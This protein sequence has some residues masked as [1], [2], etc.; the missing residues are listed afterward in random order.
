MDSQLVKH[1]CNL[2]ILEQ[3]S[4]YFILTQFIYLCFIKTDENFDETMEKVANE[5][6]LTDEETKDM[7]S[8]YNVKLDITGADIQSI[9]DFQDFLIG[10]KL[11]KN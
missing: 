5:V 4:I 9:K 6:G 7:Y 8:W 10:D 2:R 11:Q 1:L 3:R